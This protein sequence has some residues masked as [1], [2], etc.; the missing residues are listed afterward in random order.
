MPR[1]FSSIIY[2]SGDMNKPI[3]KLSCRVISSK[4]YKSLTKKEIKVLVAYINS[5]QQQLEGFKG[6]LTMK[7]TT[8][9]II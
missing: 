2:P 5:F 6:E 3:L 9:K 4:R 1:A 8:S 7:L